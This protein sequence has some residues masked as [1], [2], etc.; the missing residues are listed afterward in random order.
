[1]DDISKSNFLEALGRCPEFLADEKIKA[2]MSSIYEQIIAYAKEN[3]SAKI[4]ELVSDFGTE[5]FVSWFIT[6]VF[7][8]EVDDIK[9]ICYISDHHNDITGSLAAAL[10]NLTPKQAKDS[11]LKPNP[12]GDEEP[13]EGGSDAPE[14][15]LEAEPAVNTEEEQES[16]KT[17]EEPQEE[18]ALTGGE[19]QDESDPLK[20]AFDFVDSFG[21]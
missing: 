17:T 8:P 12:N 15:T 13:K 10:A 4:A 5:Q 9:L 16:G 11:S 19:E 7:L 21:R 1:M 3:D 14:K 20:L 18:L 2:V 6:N